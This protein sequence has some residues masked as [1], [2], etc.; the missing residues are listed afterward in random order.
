MEDEF[1]ISRE[2]R[3]VEQ[4]INMAVGEANFLL[5][6]L[7]LDTGWLNFPSASGG[8]RNIM[9]MEMPAPPTPQ[10]DTNT[11]VT[12]LDLPIE[13]STYSEPRESPL[14]TSPLDHLFMSEAVSGP[15]N[16]DIFV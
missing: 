12:T 10:K 9:G 1:N 2:S 4:A 13:H 15:G 5:F 6:K 7:L 16:T 3:D 14:A 8:D 11:D